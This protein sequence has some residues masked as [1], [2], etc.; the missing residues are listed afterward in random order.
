MHHQTRTAAA[1]RVVPGEGIGV[2]NKQGRQ[3]IVLLL[4]QAQDVSTWLLRRVQ[5][6]HWLVDPRILLN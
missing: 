3:N 5:Q 1:V 6:Q 2:Q 4:P